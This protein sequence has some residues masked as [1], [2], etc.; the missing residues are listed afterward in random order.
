MTHGSCWTIERVEFSLLRYSV[1]RSQDTWCIE[2][3]G[4]EAPEEHDHAD[5]EEDEGDL[6]ERGDGRDERWDVPFLPGLETNLT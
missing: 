3:S 6:E 4:V 2:E 1:F 5:E